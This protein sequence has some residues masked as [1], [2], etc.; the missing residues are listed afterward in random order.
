MNLKQND[1]KNPKIAKYGCYM[2]SLF[3]IAEKETG[4][5]YFLNDIEQMYYVFLKKKF[6]AENCYILRADLI[7]KYLTGKNWKVEKSLEIKNCDYIIANVKTKYNTY[8]F[9]VVDKE[10]K[11]LYDSDRI[12]GGTFEYVFIDYRLFTKI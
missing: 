7:L 12:L 2:L 3:F 8:H 11:I 10:K 6:I 5:T 4:R 1:S 9:I